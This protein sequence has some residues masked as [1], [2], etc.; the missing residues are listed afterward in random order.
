MLKPTIDYI[1]IRYNGE[2]S[3]GC[4]AQKDAI[5]P[6]I[7]FSQNTQDN[8]VGL[9]VFFQVPKLFGFLTWITLD[10]LMLHFLEWESTTQLH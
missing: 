4:V 9:I 7:I 10:Q 5:I 8:S 1:F 2:L 3:D 6:G